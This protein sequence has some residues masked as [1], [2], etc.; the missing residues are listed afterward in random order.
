MTLNIDPETGK[1]PLAEVLASLSYA[2][3]LTEGQPAGHA[4]R[5]CWIGM[6]IGEKIGL[7][8][9]NLADLYY[10]LLLKDL[11]CSSNASR[12][13]ELYLTD[14]RAF[15]R[16]FK[17]IGMGVPAAIQFIIDQTG[18]NS[19]LSKR[20]KAVAHVMKHGGE[21]VHDL[22]E[23]RCTRGAAIA[24]Q[25]RFSEKVASAIHSLDE[26]WDGSGHPQGVPGQAIPLYSR[27][28]LLSQVIDVF[29]T[30]QGPDAA[31]AGAIDRSGRWFD[32]LLVNA[33]MDVAPDLQFWE[34]LSDPEIETRVLNMAPAL[35]RITADDD[36]LDDIVLAFG[37]V[38]DAKSPYTFG[39]S[40]RVGEYAG[41]I[42]ER[43]GM[44]GSRVRW[45]KRAAC[46]HDVG[47]LGVSSAIL[48]KP[49]PLNDEERGQMR[50]H[51]LHSHAILSRI[52]AFGRL[53]DAAAA[54][55][56]R[57]DGRGYPHQHKAQQ[58]SLETRIITVADIYDALTS[59]R[60]YR[61]AMPVDQALSLI[62]REIGQ[63][64]DVDCYVALVSALG[65]KGV[66]L[67]GAEQIK[68]RQIA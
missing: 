67:L 23:T 1:I 14:D 57:L 28:A 60:P 10:T 66:Q 51:A 62:S 56:E 19:N 50:G 27:I 54:H 33:F 11:G 24:R 32:P 34:G 59:D 21:I 17:T 41:M 43:L 7:S 55:H 4:I 13:A 40:E 12:I 20:L 65:D 30:S 5:T 35:A 38:I 2:L 64:V 18:R 39:H 8:E 22:I 6:H 9:N 61:V 3:D 26:H 37:Q 49:G 15:K 52:S 47:K 42:G 29:Y 68:L 48:D 53:A 58:I 45:L 31:V 16:D 63:A 44:D 25:M 46:L 36:W